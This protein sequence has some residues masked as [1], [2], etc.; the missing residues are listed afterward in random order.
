MVGGRDGPAQVSVRPGPSWPADIVCPG[1]LKGG[2]ALADVVRSIM[3]VGINADDDLALGGLDGGVHAG[4][5]NLCGI[6][7]KTEPRLFFLKVL[8]DRASAIRGHP[9]RDDDLDSTPCFFGREYRDETIP[10]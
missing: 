4:G 1:G 6:V 9:I 8:D 3:R 5:D 10:D 7:D 2:D